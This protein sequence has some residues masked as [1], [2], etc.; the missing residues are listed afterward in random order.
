MVKESL[1]QQLQNLAKA[2]GGV[3]IK[4]GLLK[5]RSDN[6]PS[7]IM[8]ILEILTMEV[9]YKAALLQS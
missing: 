3:N 1:L 7:I 2:Q 5:L 8:E 6:I 4:L 9:I